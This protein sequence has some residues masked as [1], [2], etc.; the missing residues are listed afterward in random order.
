MR[1]HALVDQA[2]RLRTPGGERQ[3]AQRDEGRGEFYPFAQET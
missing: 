1:A 3:Y 2:V